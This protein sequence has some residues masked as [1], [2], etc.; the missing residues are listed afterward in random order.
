[1]KTRIFLWCTCLL[2][3]SVSMAQPLI[4]YLGANGKYGY[5]DP[6][7]KLVYPPAYDSAS[8]MAEDSVRV[9]VT[10]DR[11]SYFLLRNGLL[12]TDDNVK[13]DVQKQESP[14]YSIDTFYSPEGAFL[15][16]RSKNT[17][18]PTVYSDFM[19]EILPA[20]FV[21]PYQMLSVVRLENTGL[22]TVYQR[23]TGFVPPND[24]ED[25]FTYDWQPQRLPSGLSASG[26]I[27]ATG[28]W[29]MLPKQN[30]HFLPMSHNL[31]LEV[32]AG[33]GN[34]NHYTLHWV[35]SPEKAVPVN[36]LAYSLFAE[37]AHS[38]MLVQSVKDGF[39]YYNPMGER[40]FSTT[41]LDG[42]R[43]LR[44]RNLI[45]SLNQENN[46]A[47]LILDENGK[48]LYEFGPNLKYA[49]IMDPVDEWDGHFVVAI[50][51]DNGFNGLLDST[52]KSV[53][54]FQYRYL[55]ILQNN[56]LLSAKSE[57]DAT[58]LLD[59]NGALV[60]AFPKNVSLTCYSAADGYLLLA[61]DDLSLVISPQNK[62]LYTLP[63]R[64]FTQPTKPHRQYAALYDKQLEKA[65][66]VHIPSGKTFREP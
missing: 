39:V 21:L 36:Y 26:V 56:R 49:V 51:R 38:N 44:R 14:I 58:N 33:E 11:K 6:A 28:K 40:I 65:Y 15:I 19:K 2:L 46:T 29:K 8:F 18:F 64:V 22:M 42:P 20:G 47:D 57:T 66:W 50:R 63:G 48:I 24:Y 5:V 17:D 52:G 3:A 4:P 7:G 54:P 34:E 27:D 41:V 12:L 60:Y 23:Q 9:R 32:T 37:E 53:L 30:T 45:C 16:D 59:W 55:Q 13:M 31:I 25:F 35:D 61:S 10:I 62:M 1:M 43:H